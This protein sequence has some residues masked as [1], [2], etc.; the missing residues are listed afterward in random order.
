ME[1]KKRVKE[2]EFE[3]HRVWKRPPTVDHP[4]GN[5]AHC[6][7]DGCWDIAGGHVLAGAGYTP[8]VVSVL[9]SQCGDPSA[10]ISICRA[11]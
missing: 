10:M 6:R 4:L 11:P 2:P 7:G 9:A 5:D 3:G 1:E 8:H